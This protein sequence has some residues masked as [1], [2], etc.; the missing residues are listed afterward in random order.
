VFVC[1][2]CVFHTQMHTRKKNKTS[3]DKNKSCF[4]FF[5]CVCLLEGVEG[6]I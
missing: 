5:A 1:Y 2:V 6:E 3:K 4:M